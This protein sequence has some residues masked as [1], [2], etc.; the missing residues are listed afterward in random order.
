MMRFAANGLQIGEEA[1][2]EALNCLPSLNLIRSTKL[3]LTT[4]PPI[5]GRCCYMLPFYF[6]Q[7][8][9][10]SIYEHFCLTII[11]KDTTKGNNRPILTGKLSINK[12][13]SAIS[14]VVIG[15]LG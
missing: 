1:D 7:L 4:E 6:P 13:G 12:T 10:I 8:S 15:P 3:D 5:L 9:K 2:F 14:L 11:Y